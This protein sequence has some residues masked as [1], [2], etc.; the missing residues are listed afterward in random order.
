M[1]I[2]MAL[3]KHIHERLYWHIQV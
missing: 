1:V 3:P 2:N